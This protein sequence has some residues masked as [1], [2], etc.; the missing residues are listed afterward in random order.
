MLKERVL[1]IKEISP[2]LQKPYFDVM[3]KYAKLRMSPE[4]P[5]SSSVS[6]FE[7]EMQCFNHW[8]LSNHRDFV[9]T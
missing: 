6:G 4:I 5:L 3:M 1:N 2:H 7:A 8:L 9:H